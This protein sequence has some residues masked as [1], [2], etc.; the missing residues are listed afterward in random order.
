MA[1]L[2][3]LTVLFLLP[4]FKWAYSLRLTSWSLTLHFTSLFLLIFLSRV[5]APKG[6][7]QQF[8]AWGTQTKRHS[9]SPFSQAPVMFFSPPGHSHLHVLTSPPIKYRFSIF[10]AS[11][12]WL[13]PFTS[14][15][16]LL[17]YAGKI[18]PFAIFPNSRAHSFSTTQG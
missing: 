17:V 6:G 7:M 9:P 1:L 8:H 14:L 12:V 2:S 5:S 18:S 15:F 4:P 11:S 10:F 13:I 3:V 16:L